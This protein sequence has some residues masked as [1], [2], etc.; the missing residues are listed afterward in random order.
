MAYLKFNKA[1]LVNLEYSLKREIVATNMAGGYSNST[2]VCCNTRKYHGLLVVPVE[3]FGGAKYILLS[4]IDE[5]L[6]QHGQPFNLGIHCYG[7]VYEPRGHKYIVNCEM[8]PL[9]KIT[10]RV[11]GMIFQKE[12][13]FMRKEE[14]LFLKYT[15]LDAH[16][17]TVLRLKP[18]LAFRNTHSLTH[19]NSDA[20]THYNVIDNGVS[21]KMYPGFPT[22]NL[23]VSK[24]CDYV[25]N[26]DWYRNIV[27]TEEYRRGFDCTEDL[28]VPGY[29][30]MPISKGESVIFSAST[31]EISAGSFKQKFTKE[32]QNHSSINNYEECL[33]ASAKQLFTERGKLSRICTGYSWM[34]TGVLRD[35]CIDL[36]GL[37]LYNDGNVKLFKKI[38]D[39]L[40]T[41]NK[42]NILKSSNQVEAPLRLTELVQHLISFTSD[43]A[44]AWNR[45]GKLL[46]EVIIS[47]FNG[48]PE[49]TL[50]ENGMLWAEKKG[51]ALS[52]MNAYIDGMPVTERKGY[53]V[54]T[55]VFW[56]NALCFA[57]DMEKSFG[58]DLKFIEKCNETIELIRDNFHKM[59]W[60]ESRSHLADYIDEKGQ[61]NFTRPS[62]VYACSL[63][64]TPLD[65]ESQA[66]IL[67]AITRELVTTKGIRTLSPKNPLYKGVYEGNQIQRDLAYHNGCTRPWLLGPYVSA[68]FKLHGGSFIR[69]AEELVSGFEEDMNI[70]GIGAVCEIYDGDPPHYPHGAINSAVSTA[71]ILRIKYMINKYKGEEL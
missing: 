35:T 52:W 21:F 5:T 43:A 68:N 42:D 40:I 71:E 8:D 30:E 25:A 3:Q 66:D 33:K 41:A 6:V 12:F 20:D 13:L 58:K 55:N 48:R 28:F 63:P 38:L 51:V 36:P 56:Y 15:L 47:Y 1:E 22:L 9:P 57:S 32:L 44:G 62:Q 24:K 69:K 14:R 61:N 10:Y 4:S 11:G 34:D 39:D 70:H 18:F 59:F 31:K 23:Q 27:Y 50:H 49:V 65:D 26:P 64:Y 7:N 29:F 17:D 16:S 37:T 54:E 53:Q 19:A 60:V 45:Y 46:K 67:R 2:I